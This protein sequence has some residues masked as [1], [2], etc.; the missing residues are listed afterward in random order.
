M[1]SGLTQQAS[2]GLFAQFNVWVRVEG[3]WWAASFVFH[4]LL[5]AVLMLV[6]H[7]VSTPVEGDAPSIDSTETEDIS[8]A[9]PPKL[10]RFE[11][12]QTTEI[13]AELNTETL[14]MTKAPEIQSSKDLIDV[15]GQGV[16]AGNFMGAAGTGPQ[17]S[18][19]GGYSVVGLGPGSA[20]VAKGGVG[21][22][23]GT[24]GATGTATGFNTRNSLRKSIGSQGGTKNSE[25][26]VAAALNWIARHQS[27]DGSW[28]LAD[29][30]LRCKDS[31]CSGPGTYAS[32]PAATALALLP[33]FAAGQTHETKGPYRKTIYDGLYWLMRNQKRWGDS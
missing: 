1:S 33:Y 29:Y 16:S 14:T 3:A 6:P 7:T 26:S 19:L 32:N 30:R 8:K 25:R 23:G 5:M 24:P 2:E 11:V 28:S 12:G 27:R 15:T 20:R 13:P 10:E 21:F 4:T 22:G 9:P 17:L 31:T 18:G